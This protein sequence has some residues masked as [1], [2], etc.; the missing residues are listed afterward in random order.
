MRVARLRYAHS[1]PLFRYSGLEPISVSN[2]DSIKLVLEGKVDVAF[3][4]VTYASLHCD[5]LVV[6]PAFAIYSKGPVVSARLFKGSG[7]GFAAVEDTSVNAMAIMKLMGITF[8]RVS[9]PINALSRYEGVLVIGDDALR[10]ADEGLPYIVDVGELWESRVGKP[11][12]YAV[13]VARQNANKYSVIKVIDLINNSLSRFLKEPDKLIKEV[14]LRLGI[15]V[16]LVRSYLLNS[17][18]YVV[19]EEVIDGLRTELLLFGLPNC[20]NIMDIGG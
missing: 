19:N 11:L 14:S 20:L 5:S 12:V 17:I 18:R 3:V 10:L 1:D 13:M 15:S 2:N 4:P 6:V 8:E 9:D 16:N 7:T